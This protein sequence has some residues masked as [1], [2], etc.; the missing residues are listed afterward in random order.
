MKRMIVALVAFPLA[1][2]A[3]PSAPAVRTTLVKAARI[4]NV[5]ERT[6][7]LVGG[8]RGRDLMIGQPVA[9]FWPL[10]SRAALG[11]LIVDAIEAAGYRPGTDIAIALDPAASSLSDGE[12]Y[13]LARSGTGL[14]DRAGLLA[15]YGRWIDAYPIVSIE[16]GLA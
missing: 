9:G 15:L 13:D 8:N 14:L 1:A 11:E 5:N 16:D 6:M 10:E 12:Q 7:R 4:V 2:S 3:Q